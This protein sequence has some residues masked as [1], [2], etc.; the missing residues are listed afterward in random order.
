MSPATPSR[1]QRPT[2]RA[3]R[4]IRPPRTFTPT[5]LSY[6]QQK[7]ISW[8]LIVV[9]GLA[10][11]GALIG[12]AGFAEVFL[13]LTG[14][15]RFIV[16]GIIEVVA[17]VCMLLANQAALAGDTAAGMWVTVLVVTGVAV[18]LQTAHGLAEGEPWMAVVYSIASVLTVLLWRFKMRLAIRAKLREQGMI[19][20]PLPRYRPMRWVLSPRSTWRA[21]YLG[22]RQGISDPATASDMA[23]ADAAY[24]RAVEVA[25]QQIKQAR[26]SGR[27][28]P[29]FV[30]KQHI[31]PPWRVHHK[32]ASLFGVQP[33]HEFDPA[34][35]IEL[36]DGSSLRRRRDTEHT[37]AGHSPVA[38]NGHTQ[39]AITS[40]PA[41]R[42][43]SVPPQI[44]GE[45]D[46]DTSNDRANAINLWIERAMKGNYL[47]PKELLEAVGYADGERGERWAQKVVKDAKDLLKEQLGAP[48]GEAEIS[49]GT[50]VESR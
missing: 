49:E 4:A 33:W 27:T 8:G 47:K 24:F 37:I 21:W 22:L 29:T 35:L 36:D 43:V 17:V 1:P 3:V 30:D 28:E 19:E 26:K 16:F 5:E 13:H 39:K 12:S 41:S 50:V 20:P 2:I 15:R 23:E 42:P 6:W 11:Y 45:S 46:L 48:I 38:L 31:V 14:P 18:A 40:R 25:K 9:G 32:D 44:G 34:D 7:L 10:S